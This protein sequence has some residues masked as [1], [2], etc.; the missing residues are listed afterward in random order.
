MKASEHAR[1]WKAAHDRAERAK[2]DWEALGNEASDLLYVVLAVCAAAY[3]GYEAVA[4]EQ[5]AQDDG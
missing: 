5:E 4:K 3:E 1:A 2:D